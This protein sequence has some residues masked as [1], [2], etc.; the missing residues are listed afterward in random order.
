MKWLYDF[1][2]NALL[3]LS[4]LIGRVSPKLKRLVDG[5]KSVFEELKAFRE[6]HGEVIWFHVASLGEYEQA[7]P[8][9]AQIKKRMPGHSVLLTFF[10]PSGY[11][12]VIRKPQQNVDGIFYLPFDTPANAVRFVKLVKP[13]MALFAKYDIWPNYIAEIKKHG[14]PLF[15]FSAAFRKEQVYFK[16]GGFLRQALKSFDHIFTQNQE[17]V[18]LLKTIN[19]HSATFAGDTRFDN[20]KA[21]SQNPKSFPEIEKWVDGQPTIVIGSAWQEDMDFL[22]PFINEDS[23]YKFIIAP[24]EIKSEVIRAWEKSIHKQ[25]ERYSDFKGGEETEV[26]F[27]DNVGMLSSLYQFAEIAYVGGAFKKGLHNILEPLAFHIPVI[28]GKLKKVS[29]FPEAKISQEYGCG[30]SVSDADELKAT[31]GMLQQEDSGKHQEAA[32]KMVT[33][34]LGS[35]EKIVNHIMKSIKNGR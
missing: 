22:I 26:L 10:S 15:L 28:F 6:K 7:K 23:R 18:E 32:A 12:N 2:W 27:I 21:I 33:E 11:E 16:R 29:K 9:M 24:H 19:Y 31:I 34:N 5:R 8:V 35:A 14:I 30:F 1:S 3:K 20:V 17:S 25:S 13:S 4:P